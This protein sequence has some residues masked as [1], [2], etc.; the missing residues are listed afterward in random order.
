MTVWKEAHFRNPPL[1][2]SHTIH[3]WYISHYL[4][5]STIKNQAIH[6]LVGKYTSLWMVW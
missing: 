3:V 6:V 4:P 1:F 5:T 2:I